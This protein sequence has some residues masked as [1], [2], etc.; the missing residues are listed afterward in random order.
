MEL[1]L[2]IKIQ[3]IEVIEC[4]TNIR[5][6]VLIQEVTAHH[7]ADTLGFRYS[8]TLADLKTRVNQRKQYRN[9]TSNFGNIGRCT[10]VH[11]ASY[12]LFLELLSMSHM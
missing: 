8:I 3:R 10:H 9:S 6:V 1:P 5:H 12:P 2:R 7:G 11:H 4:S